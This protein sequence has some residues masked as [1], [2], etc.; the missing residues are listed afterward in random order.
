MFSRNVITPSKN[1]KTIGLLVCGLAAITNANA[2]IVAPA[3]AE[4]QMGANGIQTVGYFRGGAQSFYGAN[5]FSGPV[6]INGFSIRLDQGSGMDGNTGAQNF[7]IIASTTSAT[8]TTLNTT[9]PSLN[10]GADQTMVRN[11]P[12]S[13]FA[14]GGALN[15]NGV[16]DWSTPINFDTPFIYDPADGNLLLEFTGTMPND[17][18]STRFVDGWEVD[19]AGLARVTPLQTGGFIS[20]QLGAVVLFN[21]EPIPEPGSVLLLG[22]AA[23][24]GFVR[25]R[26]A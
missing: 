19:G 15:A 3:A 17:I 6:Q 2:A 14:I 20:D 18:F 23:G 26:R 25:R 11:S 22:L 12:L 10:H 1:M 8:A 13:I 21:T 4:T 5:L 9:N 16:T 7:Q 24:M